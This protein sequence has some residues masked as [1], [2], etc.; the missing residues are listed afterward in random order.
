VVTPYIGAF[1]QGTTNFN[2]TATTETVTGL[3]DGTAY[4]FT[5]S[6]VNAVGASTPSAPS[7]ALTPAV[8]PP[9]GVATN[10]SCVAI[11]LLPE[12]T[13]SWTP[14]TSSTVTSYVILRG[15]SA[16]SLSV[17]TTVS[18]G[19]TSYADTSVS[20]FGVTYWYAVEA[21]APDGTAESGAVSATTPGLCL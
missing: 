10:P 8:Q 20:G 17:L 9:T 6:A 5:V 1:A 4:S 19:T 13:V 3:T 15:S 18:S 7:A 12:V 2:S 21:V 14:S 16:G 11:V